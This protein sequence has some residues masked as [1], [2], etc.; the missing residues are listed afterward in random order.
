MD[1][2]VALDRQDGVAVITINNP[3][4]N[5]LSNAV[6]QGLAAALEEAGHDASLRAIVIIGGG[7]TFIAGADIK[8]LELAASG[9]GGGPPKMH[10]L[11]ARI[12]DSAAPV[13]MAIHGTALGGGLEIAMAGHYRVATPDAQVGQPEVNLGIIPGAEGTQRLPRLAGV[14][15][16]VDLCVSGKPVRAPEAMRMGVIDRIIEGDLRAG[17]VAFAREM[18]DRGGPHRKTRERNDKLGTPAENAPLF[19]AGREQARKTRRE[20]AAGRGGCHRSRRYP[21]L[22]RRLQT[23]SGNLREMPGVR[24][25]ARSDSRLFCRARGGQD[26]RHS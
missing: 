12:E 11:F 23:R 2:L 15:A 3:P 19:A 22:R 25:G 21:A 7:R 5:A 10:A 8:E 24:P 4:V 14:A 20:A 9:R 26:S 1:Q 18:A 17:A 6:Q 16:A 13:I